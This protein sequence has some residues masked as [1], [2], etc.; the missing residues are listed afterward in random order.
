MKKTVLTAIICALT[1]TGAVFGQHTQ[2]MSFS[3]P[4]QWV[5]GTTVNL[6]ASLTFSGYNAYGLSYWLE[7]SNAV[8]PYLAITDIQWFTFPNHGQPIYPIL[9]T[10]GGDPGYSTETFDLGGSDNPPNFTP[11]GTYHVTTITFSLAAGAPN[12]SYTM[13]TTI[14]NPLSS[15]VADTDFNDND[16][17]HAS[18]TITVVPEP[19]T[20]ALLSFAA[21]GSGLLIYGRRKHRNGATDQCGECPDHSDHAQWR[22]WFD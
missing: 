13:L 21:V 10:G 4:T 19:S 17:P 5:P 18:F 9:F 16:I 11:P 14:H 3:G 20:L 6:D 2:S 8:A 1:A 12:G 7:V 22:E 15:A